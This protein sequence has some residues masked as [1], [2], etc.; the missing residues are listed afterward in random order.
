MREVNESFDRS[1]RQKEVK[2]QSREERG[3]EAFP[4]DFIDQRRTRKNREIFV[5]GED[6]CL[7]AERLLKKSRWGVAQRVLQKG[8]LE[9]EKKAKAY[10]LLGLAL[11]HQ[12]LFQAGL[13]QMKKACE[14]EARP[15]YFLNLSIVLNELGRYTEAKKVYE[16][17]LLMK[18]QSWEQNWKKE[19]AEKHSKTALTYL[20]NKEFK[21]ALKE[22]MKGL[23]FYQR[24]EEQL[25]IARLLWKLDQKNTAEKYL[26][27]FICLYPQNIKARLLLANWCFEKKQIPQAVNEW[28]TVLR[29]H[30]KNIE[31]HNCLLKVQQLSQWS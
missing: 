6:Y 28:E 30:P 31:A 3:E 25:Q 27:S 18:N 10:H 4:P 24:P 20:R 8:L 19:V 17:A 26:K 7:R 15:E 22:Y 9:V 1:S 5:K 11:Y 12:G 16:K 21:S 2:Y 29:I 23:A 13:N 14:M